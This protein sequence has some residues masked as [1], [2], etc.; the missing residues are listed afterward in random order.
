MTTL[1]ETQVQELRAQLEARKEQ[2]L[3]ELDEVQVAHLERMKG[4]KS[5]PQDAYATQANQVAQDAVRDAEARRDHDEL[6]AVRAAL[7]RI[8]DGSYGACKDCGADVGLGRL[9]AF[10]AALRCINCQTKLEQR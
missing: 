5:A 4:A 7:E 2:L 10:P 9:K 3:Q 1:T 8:Q 6:V